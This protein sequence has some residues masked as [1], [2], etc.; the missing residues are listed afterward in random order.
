MYKK[1][2]WLELELNVDKEIK[3]EKLFKDIELKY[4]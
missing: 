1:K 3:Y 4:V 2:S